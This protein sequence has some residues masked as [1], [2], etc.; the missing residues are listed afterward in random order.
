MDA[1]T[2]T[3]SR[4][5]DVVLAAVLTV[6]GS[7]LALVGIFGAQGELRG[8]AL[9]REI[10]SLLADE[11][12]SA[13]DISV[14]A[15]LNAVEVGLMVGAAAS[16]AAIVLAVYAARGHNPSRI[17]LTVL[18]GCAAVFVLLSGLPGIAIALFV[19]YTVSLLWRA[20]VRAWFA[21]ASS[22]G[23]PDSSGSSSASGGDP[24]AGG[25]GADRPWTPGEPGPYQQPWPPDPESPG[26]ESPGPYPA[27][28]QS[29]GSVQPGA[30]P[31][32]SRWTPDQQPGKPPD[33]Q[34]T[35]QPWWPGQQPGQQ[36]PGGYGHGYPAGYDQGSRPPYPQGYGYYGPAPYGTPDRRPPHLVT[37]HVLTW[38]GAGLGVLA[39]LFFLL[40]ST[41]PEVIDLVME[42]L[43]TE[44]ISE[45]EFVSTLRL[46]GALTAL[47]S[48]AVLV[49]SVFSWRRANWAVIVLTVMGGAYM[50]MQLFALLQ[51]Q[52]AV[53]VTIAWVTAVVV[54]LWWPTSRQWY[55]GARRGGQHGPPPGHSPYQPSQQPKRRNQ[56]W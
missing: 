19:A 5:R 23:P 22:S 20:P 4:P 50:L 56:P 46:A 49:V 35:Q 10:E 51:G 45:D 8:S 55:A 11:R 24:A 38:V 15:V 3:P 48:A 18:G 21:A 29:Q 2:A 36:A 47:W 14:D 13:V 30:P 16:V 1:V 54:L 39:G 9:R 17:A 43:P 32:D 42:Q 26:A 40:A 34:P 7:V 53:V 37:A 31:P 25:S 33:Q 44:D 52:F 6:V 28:P 12:L 27:D 41:S